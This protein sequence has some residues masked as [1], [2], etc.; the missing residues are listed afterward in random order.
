MQ[1]GFSRSIQ[2]LPSDD[3]SNQ[4]GALWFSIFAPSVQP[5]FFCLNKLCIWINSLRIICDLYRIYRCNHS[6]S[7]ESNSHI[8][9]FHLSAKFLIRQENDRLSKKSIWMFQ[10]WP[11]YDDAGGILE[12][13][14][15]DPLISFDPIRG[16]AVGLVR[17]YPLPICLIK[18]DSS[19]QIHS[20]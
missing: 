6:K 9:H 11:W 15:K 1:R 16:L 2:T 19:A 5:S 17:R 8:G 4:R 14:C 13:L 20:K 7:N 12:G 10:P 3:P 18:G